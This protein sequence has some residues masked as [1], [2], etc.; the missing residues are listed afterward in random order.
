MKSMEKIKK[1]NPHPPKIAGALAMVPIMAAINRVL[2]PFG[3]IGM[4]LDGAASYLLAFC[5]CALIFKERSK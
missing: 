1:W 5:V 2:G 3:F 4:G